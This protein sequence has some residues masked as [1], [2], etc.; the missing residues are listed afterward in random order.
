MHVASK[1][2][3]RSLVLEHG[4]V[5]TVRIGIRTTPAA[6]LVVDVGV[7]SQ[8]EPQPGESFQGLNMSLS[9]SGSN[10]VAFRFRE[11]LARRV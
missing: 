9:F 7:W 11:S 1:R 3:L 10:V 4:D 6:L 2:I 8:V 5:A